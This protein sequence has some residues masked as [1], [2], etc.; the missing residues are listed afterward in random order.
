MALLT[1]APLMWAGNAVVGRLVH[2]LVS[3]MLLNFVRWLLAFAILLPLAYP[4]LRRDSPL[5]SHWKRWA[6]IGLLGIGCYN[7]FQ[8]MALKTSGPINV[9]LVASSM[10]L[11]MMAF[12]ALFFQTRITRPQMLGALFSVSGVLLVLSHGDWQQL[13]QLRLVPGDLFMLLSTACWSLY[14]WLL[15]RTY[16]PAGIKSQWALLLM[17]Q[18]AFGLLWSG[19][20]A[21]TEWAIG[22]SQLQMSST[23]LWAIAYIVIGPA[24]LAYRCWGMGVQRVGPTVA[25]FFSNLTPLFAAV[26]SAA[27]LGEPPRLYHAAAFVLVV[28]GIVI[29][30]RRT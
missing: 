14:S 23:L 1:A 19:L 17:A 24:I 25:G 21:G 13:T 11:W 16:E 3:P 5:W 7:A 18:L 27:F 22:A 6:I 20:F 2:E 28:A 9:T 26:L 12:G 4:L 8:Y 15:V 10:P 30:S 29:S